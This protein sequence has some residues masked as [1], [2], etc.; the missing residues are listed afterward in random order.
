MSHMTKLDA[1]RLAIL[2]LQAVHHM[3]VF[4]QEI[5]PGD[6]RWDMVDFAADRTQVAIATLN[7]LEMELRQDDLPGTRTGGNDAPTSMG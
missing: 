1:L 2:A 4:F 6:I 5:L 7:A 3:G